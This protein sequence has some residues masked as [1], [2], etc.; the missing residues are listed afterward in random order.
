MQVLKFGGS[1]V[2]NAKNMAK[3]VEIVSAA[4]LNDRTI[5]VCSAI[6]G[7]TDAL[8]EIGRRSASG[9][10]SYNGMI[11][12]LE[13]RHAEIIRELLPESYAARAVEECGNL[14][15]S[16]RGIAH[17]VYLVKELSPASL[18]SI[19]SFGELLSTKIILSAFLSKGIQA[20]WVDSR[21][22]VHKVGDIV[23]S[24]ATYSAVEQF[25]DDNPGVR[26]F[27]LPG[28]IAS[29]ENG[30]TT[31][32]GRGGSDYTASLLAVGASAGRLEIWTDVPGMMTADPKMVESAGTIGHIS[33]RAALELSHFGAKVIFAPT[34]HP[35]VSKNIPI[36]IKDTFNPENPGTCIEANPPR[37]S[38]D[39][40]IG[41]CNSDN[42]A[43]ISLEGSGMVGVP[44]FSSRLFDALS[45][46]GVSIIL[47][48]QASS[49]NTM[50]IAISE[51]DAMTAKKAAD[52]CF[53][54][55]ISLGRI[56][57]LKV[58][59]GYSIVCLVG[60]N[61]LAKSGVSGRMLASFGRKGIPVRATAQGSSERSISVIVSSSCVKE[62]LVAVHREFFEH[63]SENVIDLY[64]AGFGTIGK[65]LVGM[66]GENV[67]RIAERT[68]K[69]LRLCGLSNKDRYVICKDGMDCLSAESLL[70]SG[71]DASDGAFITA[72]SRAAGENSVFVDCTAST[73]ICGK[74][75][76]LIEN[77][78]SIVACNKLFF[79]GSPY[80]AFLEVMGAA[81]R[82]ARS[83]KYE[84]TVGAAIPILETVSRCVNSG[85]TL[86]KVEAVLS[87]TLNY[88][89]SNYD[90]GDFDALLKEASRLGYT[91]PDPAED[92]SGRDV[93][94]KLVIICRN[95]GMAVSESDVEMEAF[96][97][98]EIKARYEAAA[99][100][101]RRLRYVA[102]LENGKPSIALRA[103][104]KENP[105]YSL[106]GTDNMAVIT[107]AD[108]PSP[109]I[110]C[111]AGAGGRQTAGGLLNDILS[112]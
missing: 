4:I 76:F 78:F 102:S 26:L 13:S 25:V 21:D 41:I 39:D 28:F 33:Y 71:M 15:K 52:E 18:A 64:I 74:Y 87:G 10:G 6:G 99:A 48:T 101:G 42:I 96:P 3:V 50:C 94:R 110:L 100:E 54:Y 67:D 61:V 44:G 72:V 7:C 90:G 103:V 63:S 27:I 106:C 75:K 85:D 12:N 45:R 62:A 66:I 105:L 79:A 31:T 70:A 16:L 56:N 22:I 68:G 81:A 73:F 97:V 107:T 34:I 83:V 24:A 65:C 38:N 95:A 23:D 14:F 29:D 80:E 46:S 47:I 20:T 8:I 19:E 89:C 58:E 88:L 111:G 60:D 69:R 49:V 53:A 30:R 5:L 9:D 98:S 86:V 35:V 77:G 109:E 11:D 84:T 104:G 57:P 59:K 91:E 93:L 17:G 55:D 32:L 92:L 40:F 2:A 108:Y 36:Y 82:G 51:K 43:L 37:E 112:I 1:S